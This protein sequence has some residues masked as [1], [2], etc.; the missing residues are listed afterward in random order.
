MR[1]R[2]SGD[3]L[4]RHPRGGVQTYYTGKNSQVFDTYKFT[5]PQ[6]EAIYLTF[7][8]SIAKAVKI[9]QANST[10]EKI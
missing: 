4:T 2:P 1:E 10:N 9:S 5:S 7:K 3:G 8:E 6:S